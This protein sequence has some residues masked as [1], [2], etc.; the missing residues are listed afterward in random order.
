MKKITISLFALLTILLSSCD[1]PTSLVGTS[2][3][4]KEVQYN[5]S[6]TLIFKTSTDMVAQVKWTEN[7]KL[8]NKTFSHKYSYD[9]STGEGIIISGSIKG[10]FTIKKEVLTFFQ[11]KVTTIFIKD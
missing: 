11:D 1:K 3:S 10:V 7:G 4:N 9:G 5:A 2:W 8:Q 6:T